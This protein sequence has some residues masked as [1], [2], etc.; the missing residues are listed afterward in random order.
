MVVSINPLNRDLNRDTTNT[1][2][3]VYVV[4]GPLDATVNPDMEIVN[5]YYFRGPS[6]D[7]M[8]NFE[9]QRHYLVGS[10]GNPFKAISHSPGHEDVIDTVTLTK[11]AEN[12]VTAEPNLFLRVSGSW[13]SPYTPIAYNAP[14][15]RIKVP[16][17]G[18]F[19]ITGEFNV[20]CNGQ[21][22]ARIALYIIVNGLRKHVRK[23]EKNSATHGFSTLALHIDQT[24]SLQKDDE[25]V[26]GI[27]SV[28][29]AMT[30]SAADAL[31]ILHEPYDANGIVRSRNEYRASTDTRIPVGIPVGTSISI[32]SVDA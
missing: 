29:N 21:N 15:A 13:N 17:D 2:T 5:Q 10:Q 19:Q 30:N 28:G 24:M 27:N 20:H 6:D 12:P 4:G 23:W 3:K 16:R 25:V 1:L 9:D 32:V 31:Q 22:F 18:I 8:Q 14:C 7:G 26:F 11:T